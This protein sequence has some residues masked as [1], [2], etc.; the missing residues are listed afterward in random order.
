MSDAVEFDY[1]P[2]RAELRRA[3][4]LLPRLI[5]GLGGAGGR[6][7]GVA[8]GAVFLAF[9]FGLAG[10]LGGT[11]ALDEAM[12]VVG[13]TLAVFLVICAAFAALGQRMQRRVLDGLA[14]RYAAGWRLRFEATGV[15]LTNGRSRS[16]HD[17]RDVSRMAETSGPAAMLTGGDMLALPDRLLSAAGDPAVLRARIRAWHAEACA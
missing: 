4:A 7:R 12:P 2:T 6:F 8:G 5:P 1:A 14:A 3:G 17:W 9:L 13:G 10:G 16:V 11:P 15:T